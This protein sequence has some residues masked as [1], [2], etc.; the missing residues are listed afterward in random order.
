MLL[1]RIVAT[2]SL[3]VGA[4]PLAGGGV[5]SGSGC[6]SSGCHIA[7]E[8]IRQLNTG[9]M[10]QILALGRAAGDA[11]GWTVCYGGDHSATAKDR[12]HKGSP[13]RIAASGGP[14]DFYPDP[15]SPWVNPRS[16]GQC[17]KEWVRA[18]W[19]SLMM[20]ESGKAQ[21]TAWAFGGL[22]SYNHG[23]ANYVV[24]NPTDPKA[25]IGTDAYRAYMEEKS[26]AHPNVFVNR[27]EVIPEALKAGELDKLKT[28]PELAG[29]TYLRTECQ[30]CHLAVKGRSARGD[31]RGMGCSA[32]HIPYSVEGF[33][34]GADA[35]ISKDKPG[36]MLVHSIQASR[37][38]K[39][40]VG[41]VDYTGVPV[42]T[43]TVCHNPAKRIGLPYQ[44]RIDPRYDAPLI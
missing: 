32:C 29:I 26:K 2:L 7:I 43:C 20:T 42:A 39:V 37:N 44:C 41:S 24:N 13:E 1:S 28:N 40:T 5:W 22:E 33:Y 14:D 30:R 38:S 6:T 35:S 17:H 23:W 9:M 19:A 21:G 27:H 11:D 3:C 4:A 36:H 16:C 31:Y 8:P 25:R 12:A 18:E 10:R 34:E 15:G